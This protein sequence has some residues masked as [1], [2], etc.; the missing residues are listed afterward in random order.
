MRDKNRIFL[1]L[2]RLAAIW[3]KYSDLRLGQL[4]LNVINDPPLYYI[5]DDMLMDRM[6]EHYKNV[7]M[8]T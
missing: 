6:E 4:I 5:E 3:Y 1:I 7:N 8:T 2:F